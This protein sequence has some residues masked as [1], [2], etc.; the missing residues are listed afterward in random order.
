[1]SLLSEL[2]IPF[3]G[4][5]GSCRRVARK[6]AARDVPA[7][8]G[9]LIKTAFRLLRKAVR[10]GW[11]ATAPKPQPAAK[12]AEKT[13]A[14]PAE[15]DEK[16]PDPVKIIKEKAAGEKTVPKGPT[17]ADRLD[18]AATGALCALITLP[19]LGGALA[20]LGPHL[21]PYAPAT[22]AAAAPALLAAAWAV[23][24]QKPQEKPK[25]APAPAPQEPRAEPLP[26][27]PE[28]RQLAVLRWLEKTTRGASGIHLDQLHLQLAQQDFGKGFPRH[29]IRT[30]LEQ[31]GI[32]VQRTLRVGPVSGRTGVTRQA[33]MDALTAA[34]ATPPP[35]VES[36][37][38]EP[39]VRTP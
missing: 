25:T 8:F 32:P 6:A 21:A 35:E 38:V 39:I 29:Y 20:A 31:Y 30:L 34:T 16:E 37:L 1:M 14:K 3:R 24:P 28:G 2:L 36:D 15:K 33:I 23:A 9:V 13:A 22:A 18:A 7:G 17:R 12:T 10:V 19:A 5:G 27:T 26:D 4:L 11:A